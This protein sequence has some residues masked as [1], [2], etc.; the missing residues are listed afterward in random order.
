MMTI[1]P[2]IS[3]SIDQQFTLYGEPDTLRYTISAIVDTD[4]EISHLGRIQFENPESLVALHNALG[5]FL[6]MHRFTNLI[7]D[8]A[9]EKGGRDE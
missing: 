1:I 8:Y 7:P 5:A 2:D 4:D 9:P 3:I 6:R